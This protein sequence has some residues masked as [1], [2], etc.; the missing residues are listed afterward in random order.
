MRYTL[1][2]IAAT[3]L[4]FLAGVLPMGALA[5]GEEEEGVTEQMILM[6]RAA[7]DYTEDEVICPF[8]YHW[9]GE[10]CVLEC[11]K[12]QVKHEGTCRNVLKTDS[13]IRFCCVALGLVDIVESWYS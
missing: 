5:S 9:N 13:R 1:S 4:M 6:K 8:E 3:L 10:E 7:H 11:P 2:T 12:G